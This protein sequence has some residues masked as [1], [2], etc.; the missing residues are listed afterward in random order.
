MM[1]CFLHKKAVFFG[2]SSMSC[3]DAG[4]DDGVGDGCILVVVVILAVARLC[5]CCHWIGK[6]RGLSA[7]PAVQ[8]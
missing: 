2:P 3:T 6:N 4:S 5:R 8:I 1:W 7:W